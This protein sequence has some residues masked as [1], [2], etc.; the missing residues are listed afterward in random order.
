MD[1]YN[2]EIIRGILL[3]MVLLCFIVLF[4]VVFITFYMCVSDGMLYNKDCIINLVM[5]CLV[6]LSICLCFVS[7]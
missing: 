7:D 2:V 1:Y 6:I 4:K 3:G 5:M